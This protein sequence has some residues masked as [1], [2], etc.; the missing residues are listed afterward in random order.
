MKVI[1]EG[2]IH[3]FEPKDECPHQA[4]SEELWQE[5]VVLYLWDVE[6]EVYVFLR[7]AQL[8][9]KGGSGVGVVWLN[10]WTPDY[11]YKHSSDSIPFSDC[12]VTEDS[13]M[14]DNGLCRYQY[15]GDH[16]WQVKDKEVEIDLVMKDYHQGLAYFANTSSSVQN[17]VKNHIEATGWVEGTVKIK[18]KKYTVGGQGWR[19]HSWGKRDW[20]MIRCHR[21]YPAMF[22]K[23]L[24]IFNMTFVGDD[25][26]FVKN[27]VIIKEDSVQFCQDFE[28]VAF[29]GEDGVS[30]CGGKV[31]IELD[32][33][34][35]VLNYEMIGQS[36][37]SMNFGFPCVDGMCKVT[38]GDRVGVGVSETSTN[39]HWGHKDPFV[40][41]IPTSW[42]IME[43]GI[44]PL[45]K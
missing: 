43:N 2:A 25:G 23:D 30:N 14:A 18:G 31:T 11:Q 16:V 9:N 4:D 10:A 35:E 41:N 3:F 29:M 28:V 39:P 34:T 24:N 20:F 22:G 19:D 32:G 5:S 7:M 38:M 1:G 13:I 44:Y 33:K 6:Q 45:K 21:F 17:V 27:A 42:G 12:K 36:A 15:T 8:P 26:N 40:Y 37:V